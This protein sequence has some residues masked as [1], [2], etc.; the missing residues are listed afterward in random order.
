[1]TPEEYK[2]KLTAI[3]L[4]FEENKSILAKEY[5]FSN[6]PYKIGDIITDHIGSIK[7]EK[8]QYTLG[9]ESMKEL[10][11]CVYSGITLKKDKT[12][13]KTPNQRTV[14]QTNLK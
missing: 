10:P 7:I 8:I 4:Q 5:A 11:Y 14:H 1:M 6:N 12:P 3:K 13:T 2:S 9:W